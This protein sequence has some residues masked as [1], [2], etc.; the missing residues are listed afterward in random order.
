MPDPFVIAVDGVWG[1][2]G[3][4]AV[5]TFGLFG[6]TVTVRPSLPRMGRGSVPGGG[7]GKQDV[8]KKRERYEDLEEVQEYDIIFEIA[9]R[10]K[11]YQSTF[12]IDLEP[13]VGVVAEFIGNKVKN[14]LVTVMARMVKP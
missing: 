4:L 8:K 13:T 6:V 12:H 2:G 9:F 5:A 1:S 11:T 7:K 10:G 14:K 3:T